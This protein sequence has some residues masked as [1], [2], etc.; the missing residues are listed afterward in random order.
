MFHPNIGKN[1]HVCMDL[2][3]YWNEK[4][5]MEN[6]FY[7]IIEILDNPV[8]ENGYANDAKKLLEEDYDKYMDT[9]EEYTIKYAMEGF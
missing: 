7:G 2:L 3:N 4:T 9:V 8:P 5:T 1:G 6:V